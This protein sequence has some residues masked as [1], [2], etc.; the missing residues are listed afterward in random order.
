MK[1]LIIAIIIF[2]LQAS[3]AQ[4]RLDNWKSHSSTAK[5]NYATLDNESNIWFATN[6]GIL[7][8]SM[9][10]NKEEV[11]TNVE[12]LLSNQISTIYFDDQSKRIYAGSKDGIIEIFENGKW[13]HI[14]DIKNQKF[15]N[16][17][18]KKILNIN[19]KI[20]IA[21]GFGLAILDPINLV[22]SESILKIGS[23]SINTPVNDFLI[24]NNNLWV[25]T[26]EGIAYSSLESFLPNPINWTNFTTK[27]GLYQSKIFAIADF[28]KKLYL[29]SER[30]ILTLNGNSFEEFSESLDPYVGLKVIGSKLFYSSIL[31]IYDNNKQLV[32]IA[33]PE[34]LNSIFG[35]SFDGKNNLIIAYKNYGYGTLKDSEYKYLIPNS[36]LTNS[37]KDI[38]VD[39]EGNL[40][41]AS[42]SGSSS[43]GFAKYDGKQ[44]R[45]YIKKY[46]P[47]IVGDAYHRI[48]VDANG[49]IIASNYGMGLLIGEKD[50]ILNDTNYT[51]TLFNQNNSELRGL[52]ANPEFV[53]AGASA[54]DSKGNIWLSN[55]GEISNGPALLCF[56][57]EGQSYKSYG[58]SNPRINNQRTFMT[59]AIDPYGTKWVGGNNPS[60]TGLMYFN[61]MGTLDNLNDDI[62]GVITSSNNSNLLDNIHNSIVVDRSGMIWIG[63]PRG[64]VVINNPSQVLSGTTTNL[65]VRTLSRL[66]GD[67]NVNDIMVDALDNKWIAT[68]N[69]VWV[70][71]PLASD[72][73]A[74][75]SSDN[76]PIPTDE[77][78]KL[79]SNPYNGKVYFATSLGIYE[80][81][82]LSVEPVPNYNIRCYPQ[83]F[84]PINDGEL[85]IDG[86]SDFSEIRILTTSGE[87]IRS[88]NTASRRTIWD[89]K[90][91]K[92]NFVKSG[93]YLISAKSATG[94]AS[95]VQKIAIVNK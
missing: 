54:V 13:T 85:V 44:W 79:A 75:I 30:F 16:A 80:A 61:E 17:E 67:V 64:V 3:F 42:G 28:E 32:E 58:F 63:T 87:L 84:N 78:L 51:F 83:P 92:G 36:T 4:F 29:M 15:S 62:S 21:G 82:G 27:E 53:V 12:S 60:G 5:I 24:K 9:L 68:S 93:V 73:I 55:L 26:D 2:S 22:F 47:E 45:N 10:D 18:I 49:R 95:G 89:G 43:F 38:D 35:S 86:L 11:F 40:W 6:G 77:I 23:F 90:D 70:I 88:I 65:N 25:A 57:S 76:Y 69:G 41:I 37:I 19:G 1:K 81:T 74:Y 46:S 59:I 71:D 31:N 50:N 33:H 94:E 20:F 7:K 72:T 66:I 91:N 8:K 34:L 39:S 14:S 56:T 48:N 52:S